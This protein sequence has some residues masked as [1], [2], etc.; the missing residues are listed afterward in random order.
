[1]ASIRKRGKNSYQIIVSCGYDSTG[2][3]LTEQKRKTPCRNDGQAVGT[4]A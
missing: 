3:K 2:K 4:G 1:M